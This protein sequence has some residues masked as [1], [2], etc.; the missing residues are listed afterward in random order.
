MNTNNNDHLKDCLW[1]GWTMGT[2]G[3]EMQTPWARM[4]LDGYKTIEIRSY[5]LPK[6]LIQKKIFILESKTGERGSGISAIDDMSR[7]DDPEN[8]K[9]DCIGWC[10]FDCIIQYKCRSQFEA[11]KQFHCVDQ[12]SIFGWKDDQE[13]IMY[14]WKVGSYCYL[15]KDDMCKKKWT[16]AIRRMRSLFELQSDD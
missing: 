4:I 15:N 8:F 1:D 7:L 5:D 2:F 6:D 14:G 9:I 11:D 12:D 16:V 10:C 13:K 3:L